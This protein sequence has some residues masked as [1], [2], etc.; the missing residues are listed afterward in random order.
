M[1]NKPR[2]RRR[3]SFNLRGVRITPQLPLLTTVNNVALTQVLTA[4]SVS[5][6]RARSI[7]ASWTMT[8][9]VA[10]DG[11]IVVGYAH[12][13]YT[14]A[15]IKEAIESTGSIDQGDKTQQER[16]NRLV[17]VVGVFVDEAS[18]NDGRPISTKLNW[19]IVPGKA[20]NMFMYNDGITLTTGAKLS[21]NG[22]MW[23]QDSV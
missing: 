5:S 3:R 18:L 21:A 11:P 13:D 20:I 2:R 8:G 9:L 23:L 14:V 4:N 1:G 6:Y 15:E 7:K 16:A 12:S 22:R 17:R 19:L 10:L